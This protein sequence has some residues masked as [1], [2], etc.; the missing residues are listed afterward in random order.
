MI[1][2]GERVSKVMEQGGAS[3]AAAGG[4]IQWLGDNSSAIGSVG[5]IFG[6][7]IGALGLGL[8][9]YYKHCQ[10][11]AVETQRDNQSETCA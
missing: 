8:N 10:L 3:M 7:L 2:V 5:V 6:M 4:L 11:R 1:D 9:W